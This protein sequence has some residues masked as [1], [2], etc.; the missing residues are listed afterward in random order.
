MGRGKSASRRIYARLSTHDQ[1]TLALQL[2]AMRDM[3]R[4]GRPMTD[5]QLVPEMKQL[6]KDGLRKREIT[7]RLWASRTPVIRLLRTEKRP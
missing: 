4:K 1:K 3:Q 7:K 2:S 6:R 5:G